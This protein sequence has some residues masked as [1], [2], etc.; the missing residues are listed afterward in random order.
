MSETLTEMG[1]IMQDARLNSSPVPA[2][3][4]GE[5]LQA[6]ADRVLDHGLDLI[7]RIDPKPASTPQVGAGS[8]PVARYLETRYEAVG[9]GRH[10]ATASGQVTRPGGFRQVKS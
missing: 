2:R 1:W 8:K 6:Y 5:E 4:A 3:L 7:R 9:P 10:V